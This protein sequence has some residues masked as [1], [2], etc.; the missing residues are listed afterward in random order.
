M[1]CE[2]LN[3]R[4]LPEVLIM[5]DGRRVQTPDDWRARRREIIEL[6]SREEYGFTPAAPERV[7]GVIE[8][9]IPE[10]GWETDESAF[11]NKAVQQAI[12]LTFDTPGGSFSFP[13]MLAV[14]KGVKKAP[15]FVCIAFRKAFPDRYLPVEE[16]I[17]HG[18]AVAAFC[19]KDV[20]DDSADFDKLAALYPRDEKTGWGKIGMWA[21]AASR[22]LDYL[23]T[24]DDIDLSRVCVT[25]HSRLGKT[26]LWC[27][28]QDERFS[29]AVSNDSGCSGAA[30]SRSDV[31]ENISD[32][33]GRF[34][35]WFCGNYQAW[36]GREAELPFDQHM[37]LAL[38]APRTVYVNSAQEDEWADPESEFLS[39]VA[40]SEVWTALR[41]PGLIT[42][43][44]MPEL[45][46][47]L[48]D[49]GVCYHIR[50]G[51]HFHSRADWGWQMACR[52]KHGI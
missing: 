39:C 52:E 40:A 6:F 11:A 7:T 4:R 42:P 19:Y 47:P 18:F 48:M 29:M 20:T 27:A 35:F 36:R 38:M 46:Q 3:M 51:S 37:L 30:L 34:P 45:N 22:V 10:N 5:N 15:V 2:K 8:P 50:T 28:A 31:G 1:L 24:R 14:P 41:V 44:A 25:G 26:A 49:G 43:D 23:E 17:D 9:S 32:I 33:T 16:I 12:R 13:M 21:F